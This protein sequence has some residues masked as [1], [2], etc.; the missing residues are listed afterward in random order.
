MARN[1]YRNPLSKATRQ[2]PSLGR[3]P[4]PIKDVE[5][6]E[7]LSV[8]YAGP[9]SGVITFRSALNKNETVL[10]TV[11]TTETGGTRPPNIALP[12]L[13]NIKTYPVPGEQV[14]LFFLGNIYYLPLNVLNNP[15]TNKA[16]LINNSSAAGAENDTTKINSNTKNTFS[17]NKNRKYYV[18]Q[19]SA[20]DIIFE[21]RFGNSLKLGSTV[22]L[23]DAAQTLYSKSD[24]SANGDPILILRNDP[25]SAFENIQKDGASIYMCSTQKIPIDDGKS[26]FEGIIG[27]WSSLN[28][29]NETIVVEEQQEIVNT[30]VTSPESSRP[31]NPTPPDP[32]GN[33]SNSTSNNTGNFEPG[34]EST[35]S[36]GGPV[37]VAPP[38]TGF[39]KPGNL[40][41]SARGLRELVR[42]E[43]SR[44][45]VYDD[46][47]GKP[48]ASYD[49][50][51][52]YPTIGVGHL[53]SKREQKRF[54][55]YLKG[56]GAMTDDE[57]Q[58]LLL[59]DLGPRIRFLNNKL[60]A[61]V[62]QNMFDALLSMMF[63]TGQGN[64]FFREAV[65]LTNQNKYEE[66]AA[67]IK[68]GPVTSKG[69]VFAGLVRRRTNESNTYIA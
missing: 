57:I 54:A 17:L 46:K 25:A 33:S 49:D 3:E 59:E 69:K 8:E 14:V 2:T 37:E 24:L 39:L 67:V 40:T 32:E 11:G 30:T 36:S 58:K 64:R 12:L 48:I 23:D 1:I 28:V 53:I 42:E 4:L 26:G 22:K 63:N 13:A 47:N 27:S 15:I 20:G 60:S 62:T 41:I 45:V 65:R 10:Q 38:S 44:K 56:T 19:A 29:S 31:G 68:S 21:G 52:G 9:R 16:P 55:P 51:E 18:T 61:E 5:L 50:A 7:V 34:S 66:A 43:G 6:A 35:P